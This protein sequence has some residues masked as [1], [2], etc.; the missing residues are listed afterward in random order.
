MPSAVETEYVVKPA[1]IGIT[2]HV[3]Y[4]RGLRWR[5]RLSRWLLG[6]VERLGVV[7]VVEDDDEER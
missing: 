6:V 3:R 7:E 4:A 1:D 5:L 2:V